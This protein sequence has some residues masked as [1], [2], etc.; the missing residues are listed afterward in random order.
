[1][2][3]LSRTTLIKAGVGIQTTVTDHLMK[4]VQIESLEKWQKNIAVV[5]DE[6]KIKDGIVFDK[7]EYRIVGFVGLG[8][9]NNTLLSFEQS[10]TNDKPQ[11]AKEMLVF[12]VRGIT[13]DYLFPIAWEVVRNLECA[14]FKVIYIANR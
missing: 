11:V 4:E 7:N 14:G 1:M 8:V 3:E 6:I 2:A 12:M 9:V 10:K 13:A 5:F